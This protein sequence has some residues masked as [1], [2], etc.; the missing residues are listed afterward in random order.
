V[1]QDD[2]VHVS[3]YSL[4]HQITGEAL[5]GWLEDLP[6]ETR[7]L[8]DPSPLV[9]ELDPRRLARVLARADILTLNAR[10]AALAT[11]TDD[12]AESLRLLV[13]SIRVGGLVVV[14]TG[15][16]GCWL[17]GG[18]V[19]DP[20]RAAGFAV[21]AVDTNGAGDA[22][23][24]VFAAAL[25]RGEGPLTAA[26]RANAAAA[27]TVQRPGPAGAPTGREIDAFLAERLV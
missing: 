4:A 10:E 25:C 13:P 20:T 6:P 2:V 14:R 17:L 19:T 8:F 7:V 3:G 1:T 15:G 18:A 27:L 21:E 5:P 11:G 12:P 26:R 16:D 22:H 23:S 24:G 9:A